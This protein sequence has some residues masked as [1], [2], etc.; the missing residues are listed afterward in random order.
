MV[1]RFI[2]AFGAG[3]SVVVVGA[4]VRDIY[5][6]PKAA[7]FFA[8][9]GIIMMAAPI[10]APVVGAI[11]QAHLGWR[12][13]FLFF[14]FYGVFLVIVPTFLLKESNPQ[15]QKINID[16]FKNVGLQYA[17][18]LKTKAALGFLFFQ[19]FSFASMFAFITESPFVYMNLYQVLPEDY[20]IIFGVNIIVMA[21]FNRVTSHLLRKYQPLDIL[22]A[23]IL[24]Q[25]I[26]N[27]SL[28]IA[29]IFFSPPLS[30]VV[31]LVMF[32]VG[33]QGLIVANVVACYMEYFP[34]NS[35]TAN[36]VL[37]TVQFIIASFIAW[38]T[39][40]LHDGT[41]QPMAIMM[42]TSTLVGLTL[43]CLLSNIHKKAH[44][45]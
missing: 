7:R 9:I 35:G 33:S 15:K 44:K 21:I 32:S 12:S 8:L 36:A 31:V 28:F 26:M 2:Q 5:E 17:S 1:F 13:I 11:L 42:M 22:P 27:I 39:T 37:G 19:A 40:L 20:P 4:V 41:L 16:T 6:G 3:M 14:T 34:K 38:C 23:G 43:L 45:E 24:I 18:I 30:L 25:L 10:A 29:A